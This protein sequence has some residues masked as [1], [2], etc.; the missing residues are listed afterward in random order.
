MK[1]NRY[2]CAIIFITLVWLG[3]AIFSWLKPSTEV[4]MS[5]R[6]KLAKFPIPTEQALMKGTYI[7][8]FEKYTLDQFPYRDSFRTMKSISEYYF[9]RKNDNHG[10]FIKDGY[11]VKMEYPFNE[12]MVK[13][14]TN[15]FCKIYD[16]YGKGKVNQVYVSVIPDKAYFLSDETNHLSFE[17]S[18][19]FDIVKQELSFATYVDLTSSLSIEDYY[20]TDSHWR[21]EELLDVANVLADAMAIK[22]SND[23]IK[24]KV[25]KPFY[26]V[27]YGQAALPFASEDMYYLTNQELEDCIVYRPDT[28]KITSLFDA[29]KLESRDMYD[30]YLSGAAPVLYI[31]NPNVKSKKE[32]V[33]FRDSFASSFV[34]LLAEG[35]SKI[36]LI[37]IR[38]IGNDQIGDY[39][40]FEGTDMLFLYSATLLNHSETFRE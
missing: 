4:S 14:A 34:P 27:Y 17:Y 11:A 30:V 12:N 7:N 8:Q 13:N 23:Y 15:K 33:V 29:E 2:K 28:E 36:T 40:N 1:L 18:R 16:H 24:K 38:Y 19:L 21:Q 25:E 20:K 10:I 31:E 9:L 6:R 35:Y 37:D 3:L 22:L 39:V 5:E 32:L 26:G